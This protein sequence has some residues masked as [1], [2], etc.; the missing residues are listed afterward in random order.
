MKYRFISDDSFFIQGAKEIDDS[1]LKEAIF[2]HAIDELHTLVH[3]LVAESGDVIV[4]AVKNDALRTKIMKMP[5]MKICRLLIMLHVPVSMTLRKKFPLVLQMTLS[6]KGLWNIIDQAEKIPVIYENTTI[7]IQSIFNRLGE[8]MPVSRVACC[9][10]LTEQHIY[11]VA[12]DTVIRYG[13][14]DCNYT[15]VL[16]CRDILNMIRA[17]LECPNK[18][19]ADTPQNNKGISESACET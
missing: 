1:L 2:I 17:D 14:I 19:G 15:S 6:L 10:K 13:F 9:E 12:R 3:T 8:G 11:R 4:L 5:I 18:Q 7:V 16:V